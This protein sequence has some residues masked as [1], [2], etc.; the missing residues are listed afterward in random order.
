MAAHAASAGL[1]RLW[2]REMLTGAYSPAWVVVQTPDREIDAVTFVAN[3]DHAQFAGD[4]SL[5]DQVTL[6]RAAHGRAGSCRDYLANTVA[7]LSA[8]GIRDAHLLA[9]LEL[10][11]SC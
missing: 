3:T 1:E 5:H 10:V 2:A 9:L 11:D 4:M 6:I 7:A 8:E